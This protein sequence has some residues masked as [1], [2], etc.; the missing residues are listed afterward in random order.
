M[1]EHC[2]W[3]EQYSKRNNDHAFIIEWNGEPAGQLS[4]YS[5]K[6]KTAEFGRMVLGEKYRGKGIAHLALR[7]LLAYLYDFTLRLVVKAGNKRAIRLYEDCG[8]HSQH[9]RGGL[10]YM[11]REAQR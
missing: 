4:I 9:C 3:F 6:G 2:K 7:I 1:K 11:E 5:V 8:F 10:V